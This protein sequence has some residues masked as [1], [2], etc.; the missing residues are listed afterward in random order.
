MR[1]N[2]RTA[3][4]LYRGV[5]P[6]TRQADGYAL[7][8]DG[9]AADWLVEMNRF[10]QDALLD[11]LAAAGRLDLALMAP[12]GAAIAAFHAGAQARADHGGRAGMAWVIEGNADG[13]A[14]YGCV[15]AR[16]RSPSAG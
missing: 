16:S 5:V 6:V 7:E 2:R 11:G 9:P 12:L 1:L 10:P 4:S 3:P 8:G 15:H 13:F 14:E